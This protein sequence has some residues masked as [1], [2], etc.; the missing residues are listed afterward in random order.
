MAVVFGLFAAALLFNLDPAFA[1]M[2]DLSTDNPQDL[3]DMTGDNQS[4]RQSILTLLNFFLFFLGIVATGFII[5]GGFLY[6]TSQGED[7][8]V[9][10]AKKIITYAAVGIIVI[11]VSFALVNTLITGAGSGDQNMTYL[12]AQLMA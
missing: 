6:V 9:E 2:I 3:R 1:A 11:L 7:S 8:N 10:T 4:F 12:G 5:Y